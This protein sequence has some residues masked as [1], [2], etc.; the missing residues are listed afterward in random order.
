VVALQVFG[1]G[2]PVVLVA[3]ESMKEYDCFSFS[4]FQV[5]Y[6][7]IVDL[8]FLLNQI[9]GASLSTNRQLEHRFREKEVK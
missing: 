7:V 2:R 1:E 4:S 5:D 3:T 8:D 6:P 9:S